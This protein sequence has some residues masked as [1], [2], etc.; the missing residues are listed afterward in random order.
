LFG[1]VQCQ[2]VFVTTT[3]ATLVQLVFVYAI[4]TIGATTLAIN[5]AFARTT[6]DDNRFA[7]SRDSILV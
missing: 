6:I 3:I 2:T 4:T 1:I 7:A 5:I